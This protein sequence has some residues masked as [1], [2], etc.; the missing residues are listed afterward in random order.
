MRDQHGGLG[1]GERAQHHRGQRSARAPV[2]V[3]EPRLEPAAGIRVAPEK[4]VIYLQVGVRQ[5]RVGGVA[6]CERFDG[7]KIGSA[8]AQLALQLVQKSLRAQPAREETRRHLGRKLAQGT[9]LSLSLPGCPMKRPPEP[10]RRS[11]GG[12][13]R[14]GRTCRPPRLA[15]APGTARSSSR[16][17]LG[18]GHPGTFPP[19]ATAAAPVGRRLLRHR[20][21]TRTA[22]RSRRWRGLGRQSTVWAPA[23]VGGPRPAHK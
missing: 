22:A 4:G 2:P 10:R 20:G 18:A 12:R 11:T 8:I 1:A 6:G 5:S 14:T 13:G 3:E 23:Q 9:A 15:P 17:R 21:C 7:V 16:A 19:L